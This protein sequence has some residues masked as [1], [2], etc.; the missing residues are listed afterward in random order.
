MPNLPESYRAVFLL[1]PEELEVR[2]VPLK[3]P[4]PGELLLRI[5]AATTCGTDLKVFLRG[6]HPRMLRVP[7]PF[8]HEC[9]GTIAGVGGGIE[10][11]QVGQRAVVVNSAPCGQCRY[12]RGSRENL[13]RDLHYLNGA[14][15]EYLVIPPRFVRRSTYG[16][17]GELAAELAA[18]T[19]PLACVLH[20]VDVCRLTETSDILVLGGG[21]IGLLFTEVLGLQ[22][23]RVT[24]VDRHAAR[25]SVAERLGA[26]ATIETPESAGFELVIDATGTVR[27]WEQALL[28]VAA[29][30]QVLLFGG[31]PPGSQWT[32]DTAR[33]HYDEITLRGAYHHR[34]ATV[35][36]ALDHLAGGGSRLGLLLTGTLPLEDTALAFAGMQRREHLKVVLRS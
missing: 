14:F 6:G 10:G 30:G 3:P 23:H 31:C 21:P 4:A 2:Q 25:R 34:P 24:L 7:T 20:G 13:C 29:G 28:A 17:E 15:A 27:G 33:V 8:G 12:C 32:L 26:R 36:R 18:L 11:W 5:D 35:A 22:G 16:L 19:E 1:G 9:A